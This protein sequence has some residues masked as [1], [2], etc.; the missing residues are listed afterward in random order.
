M[1]E[2]LNWGTPKLC[3]L[4]ILE[5]HALRDEKTKKVCGRFHEFVCASP[6]PPTLKLDAGCWALALAVT[7]MQCKECKR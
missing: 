6:V 5:S 7:Q 2:Q 3:R 4:Q 1:K